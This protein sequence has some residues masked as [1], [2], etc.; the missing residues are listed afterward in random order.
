MRYD[1]APD[2]AWVAAEEVLGDDDHLYLVKVPDGEPLTINGSGAFLVLSIIDGDDP[3]RAIAE[4]T[5]ASEPV[6]T[7]AI[8]AFLDTLVT[9]GILLLT[10]GSTER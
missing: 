9:Q 3:W 1:L 2:V 5:H 8:Q 7:D 10:D 6:P 4:I